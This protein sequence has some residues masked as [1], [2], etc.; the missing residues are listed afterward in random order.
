MLLVI[1]G[2]GALVAL[3]AFGFTR[4][5]KAIPSPLVGRPAPAFSLALFGGGS[6]SLE[7]LRG[8]VVVVNFWASWCF[9]ACWNEAPRLEAAWRRYR[10]RGVVLVGIVYQDSEANAKEFI[11]RHGKTYPSGMD[12]GSR[13]AI[14]FGVYGVP[15][16]FFIDRAGR[17]RRKHV[18]EINDEILSTTIE[19]LLREAVEPPKTS[20][21][22]RGWAARKG[23]TGG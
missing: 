3:L 8:K 20:A 13:I 17:I 18:G 9:P 22:W 11:A 1:G 10:D 23:A 14:D 4:D 15:E 7:S 16:T 12:P 21:V 6:L 2:V 5:P 19:D